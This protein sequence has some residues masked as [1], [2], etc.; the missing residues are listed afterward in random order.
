MR[1]YWILVKE[2]AEFME[3]YLVYDI[4]TDTF[5]IE[6]PVIPVQE[7]HLPEDT[8]NPVFELAYFRSV[9]K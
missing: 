2:T 4:D 7:R 5:N 1:R 3:D 8:R 6:A 9:L